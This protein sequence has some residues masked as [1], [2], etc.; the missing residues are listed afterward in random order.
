MKRLIIVL[1]FTFTFN[2]VRCQEG[3]LFK[4]DLFEIPTEKFQQAAGFTFKIACDSKENIA[5]N[6]CSLPYVY[7]YNNTGM[8]IDSITLPT[9]K[10]IRNM[11]FDEYDNLLMMDN[12][13]TNIYR[14]NLESKKLEVVNYTKPEDW[15]KLLNHYFRNFEIPSIPT[16]YS[17]NDYLQDFYFTRFPYSYNL[18]LNYKNG[19]VYQTHYNF[20]KRITNHKTYS[21]LRK[22][23]YWFSDNLTP[24]SKILLIDDEKQTVVYY[25]RFYNL[26]YENFS[27]SMLFVNPALGTNSEPAR[28]D[29]CTNIKQNKIYGIGGFNKKG[30]QICS[31]SF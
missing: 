16:Y 29:Y 8:Q 26:I 9:T 20:I 1:V 10:C 30:I 18:Y 13:E 12:D 19:Y 2:Y 11:E 14:Y 15:F 25:D 6:A 4:V 28:F 3:K 5:F 7:L 27:N 23:D 31:W 21:N 24:K 22:A 17:N